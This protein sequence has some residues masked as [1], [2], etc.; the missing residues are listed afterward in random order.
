MSINVLENKYYQYFWWK[1]KVL[2][3]EKRSYIFLFVAWICL[4][5][6]AHR[7]TFLSFLF[8]DKLFVSGI[9]VILSTFTKPVIFIV[10]IIYQTTHQKLL[11]RNIVLLQNIPLYQL[12]HSSATLKTDINK[13]LCIDPERSFMKH[14]SLVATV[15]KHC[16]IVFRPQK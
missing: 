9:T 14:K 2:F 16:W 10:P 3:I 11:W 15:Y 6:L 4:N 12:F 7:Q 13:S 5:T 1:V 8:L